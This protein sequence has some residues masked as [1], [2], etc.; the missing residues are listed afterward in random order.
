MTVVALP[1][2]RHRVAPVLDFSHKVLLINLNHDPEELTT[3][4]LWEG[5]S[6]TDRLDALTRAGVTTLICGGISESL[7]AMIVNAGIHVIW[8]IA[9]PIDEVLEAFKSDRLNES[10]FQMPGRMAICSGRPGETDGFL[11]EA[12]QDDYNL[13]QKV[14][15]RQTGSLARSGVTTKHGK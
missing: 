5:L 1:V 3:E 10:M 8:G 2:Y 13:T 14:K 4:L 15:I 7:H 9:G 6:Q 12:L 11:E